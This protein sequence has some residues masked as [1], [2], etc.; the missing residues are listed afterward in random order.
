VHLAFG[1]TSSL[2]WR[3]RVEA[4]FVISD[5]RMYSSVRDGCFEKVVF[6]N[7]CRYISTS[8]PKRTGI[9][10][11]LML[12]SHLGSSA[13]TGIMCN[14]TP[15]LCGTSVPNHRKI[16]WNRVSSD[17]TKEACGRFWRDSTPRDRSLRCRNFRMESDWL[18][19]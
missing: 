15:R 7:C 2:S 14:A 4:S 19:T 16:S 13:T 6:L 1:L 8:H 17:A 5:E 9:P 3:G 12:S 11:I 18:K 10:V